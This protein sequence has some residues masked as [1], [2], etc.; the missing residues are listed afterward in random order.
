MRYQVKVNRD[1]TEVIISQRGLRQ[2]D[3]LSP[4]LFLLCAAMLKEA[5]RNG[6][7][8]E[9]KLCR[10]APTVSHLLFADDSL[11]LIEANA[12]NAMV[13]NDILHKYEVF[14][15]QVVNKDKSAIQF[16]KNTSREEKRKIMEIMK[17]PTEE[18]KGRY[19]GL[20]PY[21]GK[22]KS[23]AFQYIK[24]RVWKR[25]QGCKEKLLSLS[26]P[27]RVGGLG[28]RDLHSFNM[29]MLARQGWRLLQNPSLCARALEAKC[30]PGHNIIE[31][32]PKK[33]MSYAWQSI[34][35]GVQLLKKGIIWRVGDGRNINIWKDPWLP[36]GI[37]RRVT[38]LKGRNLVSRVAE[39][40]DPVTNGWDNDLVCQTFNVE[41]A[42]II[43]QIPIYE[44][45]KDCV[46]WHF[47]IKGFFP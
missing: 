37:T 36:S 30:H 14:S 8:T 12:E 31:T 47:D 9:I 27:K 40:I 29:A 11:L 5:E 32:T 16:S 44:N 42:K 17:I 3:P 34:L 23:R 24:E 18:I 19:L 20:P 39:L 46:A 41:D 4:Y 10:E 13:V 26:K 6:S 1:T 15:G 25:I 28:F 2:G 21:I 33:G 22:S 7:L 35:K 43:L 38:T 45:M